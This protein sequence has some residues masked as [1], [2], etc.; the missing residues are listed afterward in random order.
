MSAKIQS[1]SISENEENAAVPA[2]SL[3]LRGINEFFPGNA[4]R[5]PDLV[6]DLRAGQRVLQCIVVP[7]PDVEIRR[8]AIQGM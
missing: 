3:F 2:R 8:H 1:V 6:Q 4:G 7:E 5:E